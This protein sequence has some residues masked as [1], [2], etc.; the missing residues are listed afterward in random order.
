MRKRKAVPAQ[1]GREPVPA[2]ELSAEQAVLLARSEGDP[3]LHD[4]LLGLGPDPLALR[5]LRQ[6]SLEALDPG[7]GR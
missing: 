6:A 1:T 4:T 2:A 3:S 5:C 7:A